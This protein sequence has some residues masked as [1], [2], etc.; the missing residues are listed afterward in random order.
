M[1]PF[2]PLCS[3]MRCRQISRD[4]YVGTVPC[5]TVAASIACQPIS[6]AFGVVPVGPMVAM[7]SVVH[8]FRMF[9]LVPVV[10]VTPVVQ[11]V[12]LVHVAQAAWMDCVCSRRCFRD[13]SLQVYVMLVVRVLPWRRG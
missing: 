8:V 4:R 7:V 1:I 2:G 10:C 5:A 3:P 11:A 6:L 13:A 12:Q 9:P